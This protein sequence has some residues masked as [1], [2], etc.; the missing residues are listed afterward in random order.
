MLE[1]KCISIVFAASAYAHNG[2]LA[3][4]YQGD[5]PWRSKVPSDMDRF[6]NLTRGGDVAIGRKTYWS[7]PDKFRPFD[8]NEP[9]G[10]SRRTIVLTTDKHIKADNPRVTI[11]HSLEEAARCAKSDTLWICGGAVLYYITLP[12]ADYIHQTLINERF[13][14]DTYFP[15]L[16]TY[17]PE[18]WEKVYSDFRNAGNTAA[19]KDKFDTFYTLFRRIP[20]NK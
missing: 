20:K 2:R 10:R 16:P 6:K 3:I 5:I 9:L 7:I 8:K 4:G 11:A 13:P 19:P 14:G 1:G 17:N 12:Y 18:E 15:G